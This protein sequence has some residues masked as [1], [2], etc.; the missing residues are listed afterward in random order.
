MRVVGLA[1]ALDVKG[2]PPELVTILK[3]F[4]RYVDHHRGGHKKSKAAASFLRRAATLVI[5]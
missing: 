4:H 5:S 1:E 2:I 3:I